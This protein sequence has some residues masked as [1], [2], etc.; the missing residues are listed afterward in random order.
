MFG[1]PDGSAYQVEARERHLRVQSSLCEC[2]LLVPSPVVAS[3]S[4]F[5]A[6]ATYSQSGPAFRLNRINMTEKGMKS[7]YLVGIFVAL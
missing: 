4:L 1:H 7:A 5:S 3:S 6:A 2:L